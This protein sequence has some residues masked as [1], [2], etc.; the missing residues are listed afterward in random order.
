MY[1]TSEISFSLVKYVLHSRHFSTHCNKM[2]RRLQLALV[3]RLCLLACMIVEYLH[4]QLC[5]QYYLSGVETS[6]LI[7]FSCSKWLDMSV[8]STMSI[9]S[10][11][12][13]AK[14]SALRPC[15]MFSSSC[16]KWK[17]PVQYMYVRNRTT[18]LNDRVVIGKEYIYIVASIPNL[19]LTC[20][21]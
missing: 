6:S 7:C 4:L 17:K 18:V 13:S 14:S 12:S 16:A 5:S 9:T 1:L 2:T 20:E 15:R 11:L 10:P 19:S 21:F 3:P 8:A